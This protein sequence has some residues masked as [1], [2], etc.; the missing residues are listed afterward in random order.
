MTPALGAALA[1]VRKRRSMII[2]H[3]GVGQSTMT[4]DPYFLRVPV[5][6]FQRQTE[7]LLD[8]GFEFVTVAELVEMAD[9]GAPPPGYVALSFD[10]G[11]EDNHSAVL[12]V[13]REYG[14]PATVYV[15]TGLL[16]RSNPFMAP[17]SGLRMMTAEELLAMSRA[18]VELGAHS[19]THPDMSRLDRERCLREMVDSRDYLVEL[20][21]GP[22]TTFAYPFCRYGEA[23]R[24]A[25]REA[26]FAA[27]VTC[28]GRGS[29]NRFE[30]QRVLITGKDGLSTFLLKVS[31][32]H[33]PLFESLPG[34]A[35]RASTRSLR[36]QVRSAR[37]RR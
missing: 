9:G 14:L 17:G 36:R 26:G 18:G 1:P 6:T 10:D 31:G 28:A 15:T 20:T 3:H 37:E 29:W 5:E 22:V 7:L 32:R 21:G 4:E 2:C 25:A 35:V 34:R 13:L 27:A 24:E 16:G 12:P 33:Q 23:A 19:V 30:M 8:A 11:M